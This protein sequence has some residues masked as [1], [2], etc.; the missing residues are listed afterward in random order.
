[1][2]TQEQLCDLLD[3]ND[4]TGDFTWKKSPSRNVK[5]NSVAGSVTKT[6]YM[7]IKVLG[8]S[9]LA[10]RLAWLYVYGKWPKENIDHVDTNRTNN[11][12][13][14]LRE[15]TA[16]ENGQNRQRHQVNN[17]TGLLGVFRLKD[18]KN[19]RAQIKVNR[20]QIY[21]GVFETA[22]E[23]HQAYLTAKRN[24]HPFGML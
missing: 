8:N 5:K 16:I 24:M 21:L 15:A 13:A 1:M 3:Y 9:Y 6:G 2:I 22:Q 19:W 11:A 4:M 14:N 20:K 23:A 10:H 7:A 17:A 12:I 18:R